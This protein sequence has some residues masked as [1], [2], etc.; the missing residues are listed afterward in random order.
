MTLQELRE[1]LI[2][3]DRA[4]YDRDSPIMEDSEYDS[5]CGE[6]EHLVGVKWNADKVPG[7]V[8]SLFTPVTHKYAAKSL[9]K[10]N[11]EADL[12]KELVR[13]TPGIIQKKWD[14][15]TLVIYPDGTIA[16]RGNGSIGEDVTEIAKFINNKG[17][18]I[19]EFPIRG[20]AIIKKSDFDTI[21]KIKL[22]RG[23]EPYKNIRNT[24]SGL[25]RNKIPDKELLGYVHFIAY[26]L[27]GCT[28]EDSNQLCILNA[29]G[30]ETDWGYMMTF[31]EYTI[32]EAVDYIVNFD[33]DSIDYEIDGMVVKSDVF[34]SLDK[35]GVTSHHPKNA[36]AYKFPSQ[37]AWTTLNNIRWTVG[38]TGKVVPNADVEPVELLNSTVRKAS[39]HNASMIDRKGL[40]QG[41]EVFLVKAN[42][43]I[44]DIRDVRGGNTA[45]LFTEPTVCPICQQP[46][47]RRDSKDNEGVYQLY[48]DNIDCE[49]KTVLRTVHMSQKE[50]LDI[51]GLAEETVQKMFDDMLIDSPTDVFKLAVHEIESLEGFALP[52]AKKLYNAIQGARTTSLSR[53]L[54]SAGVPLVGKSKSE[55]LADE[56]GSYMDLI[57]DVNSGCNRIKSIPGFGNEIIKNIVIYCGMWTILRNFVTPTEEKKIMKADHQLIIVVTGSFKDE[58]GNKIDRKTIETSIKNAGHKTTGSVSKNTSYVLVG[59]KPGSKKDDAERLGITILTTLQELRGVI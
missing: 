39:I 30:Y 28:L 37:G 12:R 7:N 59:D 31:D 49:S 5:L 57:K 43:V 40:C 56:F 48:C 25:L 44:P 20:E 21:N 19:T 36:V 54:Y 4:Y 26:N 42:D 22:S 1:L 35:F 32:D 3:A 8:S 46:I 18:L 16:T 11:T 2:K 58:N 41:C 47:S 15:L 45:K 14:G 6:Y 10:I 33:R 9:D 34:N 55:D 13:L 52:S 29:G 38:R 24:V 50:A 51:D 53:F 17:K 27:L 23:E